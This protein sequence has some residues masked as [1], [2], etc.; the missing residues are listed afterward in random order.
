MLIDGYYLK[1]RYG[2]AIA[3]IDRLDRDLNGDP[4]LDLL[5]ANAYRLKGDESNAERYAQRAV[6]REPELASLMR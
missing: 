6:E 2:E 4:Y 3:A 5:R 1:Q